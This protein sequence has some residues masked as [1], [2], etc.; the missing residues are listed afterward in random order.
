[1][2]RVSFSTSR[3]LLIALCLAAVVGAALLVQPAKYVVA[4][5]TAPVIVRPEIS[6]VV[7]FYGVPAANVQ[8]R[9]KRVASTGWPSCA[10]LPVLGVSDRAGMF[11]LRA[12]YM[13]SFLVKNDWI[14]TEVC[15][16]RG[17]LVVDSWISFFRPNDEPVRLKCEFP[18]M[19]TGNFEDHPCYR[20]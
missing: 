10:S 6:G 16:T 2:Q 11:R 7:Y 19:Q 9:A 1:M 18:G 3:T 12:A 15:L 13:P 17:T 4:K 14:P 5:L 8:L 20:R